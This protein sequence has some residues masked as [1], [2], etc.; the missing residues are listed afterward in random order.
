MAL[1]RFEGET[2]A[3]STVRVTKAGDGLSEAL[4]LEPVAIK[5][6]SEVFL[7][8]RCTVEQVNH[9]P[10]R[11]AEGLL[12]RQHTLATQEVAMV[13]GD[14]VKELLA[15]EAERVRLLQEAADGVVRLPLDEK[16][17]NEAMGWD[18]SE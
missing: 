8:L 13:D 3:T 1:K 7:V 2:V 5:R 15:E 12:T 6:G 11:G 18:E 10:I 14:A 16:A 17:G 4:K 9:K